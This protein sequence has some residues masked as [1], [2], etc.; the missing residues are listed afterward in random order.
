MIEGTH[1]SRWMASARHDDQQKSL[2]IASHT[3]SGDAECVPSAG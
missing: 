2:Q 3:I 1:N